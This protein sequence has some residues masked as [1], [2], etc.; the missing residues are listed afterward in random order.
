MRFLISKAA[1]F[2]L[3]GGREG[4]TDGTAPFGVIH[5]S[6]ADK[7]RRRNMILW[8]AFLVLS[9]YLFLSLLTRLGEE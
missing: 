5:M 8:D 6:H 7:R 1:F 4:Q 3:D 2:C 9:L